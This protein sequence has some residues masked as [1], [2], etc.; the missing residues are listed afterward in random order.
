[1]CLLRAE[2]SR[3]PWS[4]LH[5]GLR[6]PWLSPLYPSRPFFH[7]F[8]ICLNVGI[9]FSEDLNHHM[10]GVY[11]SVSG[12]LLHHLLTRATSSQCRKGITLDPA[13]VLFP[14]IRG[15]MASGG[16]LGHISPEPGPLTASPMGSHLDPARASPGRGSSLL[17][18][19][20][21][22]QFNLLGNSSLCA[23]LPAPGV[24]LTQTVCSFL[25]SLKE[26]YLRPAIGGP[27]EISPQTG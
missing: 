4:G 17:C 18:E 14:M 6:G 11:S 25:F 9:C 3:L 5:C 8:L 27:C 7:K 12:F 24:Q 21:G 10:H 20:I 22:G 23:C 16:L 15:L 19:S 1:M 2:D 13:R 26:C